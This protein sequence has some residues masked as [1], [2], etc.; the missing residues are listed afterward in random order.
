VRVLESWIVDT[1]IMLLLLLGLLSL[2][3]VRASAAD[4]ALEGA[5]RAAEAGEVAASVG[6]DDPRL[7]RFDPARKQGFGSGEHDSWVLLWPAQGH[8]PQ[9]PW[10]LEVKAPGL[11]TFTWYPPG[12]APRHAQLMQA[13]ETGWPA[14]GR[15]A[16]LVHTAPAD[17]E[18]LRLHIEAR[19]VIPTSVTFTVR[20]IADYLRGDARWLVLATACLAVMAAMA[21]MALVFGVRLRDPTFLYYALFVLAYAVILGLQTG[22]AVE[23]LGWSASVAQV[24][25]WGGLATTVS[26]VF[27]ILFQDRFTELRRHAPG[28]RRLLFAYAAVIVLLLTLRLLPIESVDAFA[29][30]AINPL[31]VLGGPLLLA[32]GVLAAW[33]GSRHALFFLIGWTPLLVTTV[34][35]SLQSGGFAPGWTWSEEAM[36]G[37]G[38]LEAL[39][40]SLGLA[41]RSLA[42]RRDRDRARELADIDALTGLLNRRAWIERVYLLDEAMSQSGQPLSVLFL[43]LDHFKD[44][45]DRHGHEAGDEALRTLAAAMR[46]ELREQ[47]LIGRYGGEE[48]VIAL[49]GADRVHALR[50]ADRIR[51][52]LHERSAAGPLRIAQTASIGAATQQAGEDVTAL[53]KRADEAMYAAKGAGRDRVVHAGSPDGEQMA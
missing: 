28:G 1:R 19:G 10:M 49:P 40:L 21:L 14:H 42:L 16:F 17:G 30:A 9:V 20:T 24:R 31:L 13:D 48:F 8:W 27:A 34:L 52:R 4:L 46:E 35:G 2:L 39:V 37:T 29:R 12:A 47:D 53:L 43:D 51:R 50:V 45:N 18:P 7:Q 3:P 44:L 22:Y 33:R 26:V 6:R 23:P 25:T 11:Q 15:L 32:M 36:L 5:W 38:A 41:D